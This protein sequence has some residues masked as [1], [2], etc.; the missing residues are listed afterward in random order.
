[1]APDPRLAPLGGDRVTKHPRQLHR[2]EV[3]GIHLVELGQVDSVVGQGGG[4]CRQGD[5]T[6][7]R[8]T[9]AGFDGERTGGGDIQGVHAD[10]D[11][12]V[13]Q[14]VHERT[15]ILHPFG[16]VDPAAA[17]GEVVAQGKE[18]RVLV[19]D[20]E[21]AHEFGGHGMAHDAGMDT[22]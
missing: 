18:Q 1:M 6:G 2:G 11:G 10:N 12:V 4:I 13:V 22:A 19:I 20:N 9:A 21:D 16:A 3:T 5:Q 14:V 15:R 17:K 7:D 8:E